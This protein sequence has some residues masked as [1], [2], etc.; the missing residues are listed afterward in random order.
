MQG[1]QHFKAVCQQTT[2]TFEAAYLIIR[3]WRPEAPRLDRSLLLVPTRYDRSLLLS[4]DSIQAS[5]QLP[6]YYR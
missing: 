4:T 5:Q 2:D 3:A 1:K 6:I